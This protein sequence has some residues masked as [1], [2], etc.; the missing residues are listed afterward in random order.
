[1]AEAM[2]GGERP[3]PPELV[4][5]ASRPADWLTNS[6]TD[7]STV[8]APVMSA[9]AREQLKQAIEQGPLHLGRMTKQVGRM[10]AEDMWQKIVISFERVLT[11][12]G[13][14]EHLEKY[15]NRCVTN[16]LSKL[17]ATIEVLVGDEKLDYLQAKSLSDPQLNGILS[18]NHDLIEAVQGI[19]S[20]GVLSKR[21]ADVYVLTQVLGEENS[22]VAEWLDP[23]TTARAVA[24]LKWKAMRKVKKAWQDGKFEH[25]GFHPPRERERED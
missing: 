25:L 10:Q 11:N 15:L 16:K 24:T 19:R 6:D 7:V 23:P 22:V 8:T 14:V 13:P 17:R 4:V 3:A 9:E 1:M 5:E 2:R 21:E 18:Y 20:S 12:K